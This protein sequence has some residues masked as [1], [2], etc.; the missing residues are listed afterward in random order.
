MDSLFKLGDSQLDLLKEIGNIGAGHA[1]SALSQLIG[2]AVE[3]KVP[4]VKI[5]TFSDWL[6][7]ADAEKPV[8]SAYFHMDGSLHGHLYVLFPLAETEQL[9]KAVIGTENVD[10]ERLGDL[11]LESSAFGEIGN[12]LSGSYLTALSDFAQINIYA[13]PPS[14]CV[15]MAGAILGE[16][17]LDLSLYG[18][19]V[20]VIDA[21]LTNVVTTQP[22]RCSFTFLPLREDLAK[23][24]SVLGVQDG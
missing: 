2:Q 21:E 23:M 10:M 7:D 22:I 6:N 20:L 12:I 24:L 14:I 9:L 13:S 3:M 8:A 18:D 16:G 5:S 1:A 19:E 11:S 4:S 17:L 15:D